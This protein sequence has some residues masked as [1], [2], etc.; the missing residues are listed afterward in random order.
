M[1]LFTVTYFPRQGVPET[2]IHGTRQAATEYAALLAGEKCRSCP[3][4]PIRIEEHDDGV[5]PGQPWGALYGAAEIA[6]ATLDPAAETPPQFPPVAAAAILKQA[7]EQ[8]RRCPQPVGT[9]A[10]VTEILD[11]LAELLALLR[12]LDAGENEDL[13]EIQAAAQVL[14]AWGRRDDDPPPSPEEVAARA[15]KIAALLSSPSPLLA[16]LPYKTL[17]PGH[18]LSQSAD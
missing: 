9:A 18:P 3:C 12:A 17:D 5:P 6:L 1:P 16:D 7:M 13:P 15:L 14:R 2:T 10:N 8:T 4:P 11:A